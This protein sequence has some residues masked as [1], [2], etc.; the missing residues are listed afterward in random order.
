MRRISHTRRRLYRPGVK[1][2]MP[3]SLQRAQT[4]DQQAFVALVEQHL[5]ALYRFVARMIRYHEELGDLEPDEVDVDDVLDEV[6]LTALRQ[7]H[8]RPRVVTF[9]GWLRQPALQTLRRVV[10][11]SQERRRYEQVRLEDPLP[12]EE[13][14]QE[15]YPLDPSETWE[16]I[17]P[18]PFTPSPE[19]AVLLKETWQTMKAALNQ[20]P[21]DQREKFLRR[22]I[23]G[24]SDEEIAALLGR[25]IH[26]MRSSY[27]AMREALRQ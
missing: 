13:R 21:T 11:I 25:P 3:V 27:Q 9:E 19:E 5:P 7:L 8:R 4:G 18:H 24:F 14:V 15:S 6:L 26:Q 12:N 17:F 22:A 2:T 1:L 10:R 16:D 20:L 23:E